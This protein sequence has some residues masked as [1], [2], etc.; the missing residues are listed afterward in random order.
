MVDAVYYLVGVLANQNFPGC[1][2]ENIEFPKLS[3]KKGVMFALAM[4]L[5]EYLSQKMGEWVDPKTRPLLMKI[6]RIFS[7]L[8][9]LFFINFLARNGPFDIIHWLF[10][11][12]YKLVDPS[13]RRFL[14]N[15][16][17]NKTIV[18]GHFVKLFLLL[19]PMLRRSVFP[20]I[21][22]KLY[23]YSS[24]IGPFMSGAGFDDTEFSKCVVCSDQ[25]PTNVVRNT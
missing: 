21:A 19:L 6:Q 10:G 11:L 24:Y 15:E 18:W 2:L 7:V 25:R 9:G 12:R 17:L 20:V 23:M 16:Y 8:Q 4:S 1:D 3:K 22:Q 5:P 14:D 13:R